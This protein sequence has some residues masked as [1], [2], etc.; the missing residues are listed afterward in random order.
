M[1]HRAERKPCARVFFSASRNPC[2]TSG[3]SSWARRETRLKDRGVNMLSYIAVLSGRRVLQSFKTIN[4]AVRRNRDLVDI[5]LLTWLERD[6]TVYL[7]HAV[8]HRLERAFQV[9]EGQA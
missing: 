3:Q 6:I 1:Y 9:I 8:V 5:L 4:P 2:R 7:P